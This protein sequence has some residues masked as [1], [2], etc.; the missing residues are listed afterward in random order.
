MTGLVSIGT[1]A[2]MKRLIDEAFVRLRR[3][4]EAG[5]QKAAG[6]D[7]PVLAWTAARIPRV[8]VLELFARTAGLAKTRVL[9]TRPDAGLE[10]VGIGSAWECVTG[11][12]ARFKDAG[13]AW[14]ALVA[15][16]VGEGDGVGPLAVAGFA[17]S[18][19]GAHV[20]EWDGFPGGAL[21]LPMLSVRQAGRAAVL[22][23]AAVIDPGAPGSHDAQDRLRAVTDMLTP[24]DTRGGAAAEGPANDRAT[25]HG[26]QAAP[27]IVDEFPGAARWKGTV[28]KA[29]RAVREGALRKVVL[30][31]QVR[32]R[33]VLSDASGVIR[34]LREGYPGCTIFAV[35][36][37]DRCFLGATPELLVR[38]RDGRVMTGALAGSAP[39]GATGQEDRRLGD[40]LL[41]SAKDR[42][43][44]AVVVDDLR[45]AIEQVCTDVSVADSPVLLKVANVQHLFTPIAG[46]LQDHLCVLDLVER[47]HPSSAVGGSPRGEAL[48]WM[49]RHEGL[50]RGWYAGPVGWIDRAGEGEFSVAIRSALL[51]GP[52]ALLFA[53]C[54]IVA[55]SDP[56]LEYAESQ[57]KLRSMLSALNGGSR[58]TA[59][60]S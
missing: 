30:A 20:P 58:A 8:D 45:R 17:F 44:H 49:S 40:A 51:H 33:D 10:L 3:A 37:G 13:R 43:E 22:T 34:R 12:P 14:R 32:V 42:Q 7:R 23:L 31:R 60:P 27:R 19:E 18:P 24:E 26:D 48:D 2:G 46:R 28:A 11:G 6:L 5:A 4:A 15:D 39:R 41:A 56:D 47:L 21:V 29:A 59:E 50:D 55:D 57:L 16:A 54:G 9:W 25:R 52:D 36:R 35:A 1:Q 53:G 38:V